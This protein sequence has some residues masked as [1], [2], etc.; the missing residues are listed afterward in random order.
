M[1]ISLQ[2]TIQ[3]FLGG[4]TGPNIT[5]LLRNFQEADL[6]LLTFL[7]LLE[8]KYHEHPLFVR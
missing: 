2:P 5:G 8:H 6:N 4:S 3:G 1:K 7:Y